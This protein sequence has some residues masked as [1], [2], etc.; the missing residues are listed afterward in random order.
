MDKIL[1][2]DLLK[3]TFTKFLWGDRPSQYE[4]IPF[5]ESKMGW[6]RNQLP[7]I[8][9]NLELQ[10]LEKLTRRGIYFHIFSNIKIRFVQERV[11]LL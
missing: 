1:V 9:S 3:I 5:K 8:S 11:L 7:S 6:K 2:S 10:E 4:A